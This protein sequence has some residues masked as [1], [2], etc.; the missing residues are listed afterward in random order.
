MT[1]LADEELVLDRHALADEDVGRDVAAHAVLRLISTKVS[2]L[3]PS[4]I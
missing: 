3:L 1:Y 4:P 2:V